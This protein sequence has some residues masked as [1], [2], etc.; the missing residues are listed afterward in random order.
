MPYDAITLDTNVFTENGYGLEHG[1]LAQLSQFK[2]GAP[3]FVLS[4]IVRRELCRHLL[5]AAAE[6]RRKLISTVK[7]ARNSGLLPPSDVDTLVEI[8]EAAAEPE[9]VVDERLATFA[10][11]TGMSIVEAEDIKLS[12]VLNRYFSAWPPF[13]LHGDKKKEFPDA[14]ALM[15]LDKWAVAN[16]LRLLAVSNDRGWSAYAETSQYID[17]QKDLATALSMF[18]E[19]HTQAQAFVTALIDAANKGRAKALLTELQDT[20]AELLSDIDVA[21]EFDS[22]EHVSHDTVGIKIDSLFLTGHDDNTSIS[23]VRTGANRIVF[24]VLVTVNIWAS[25]T[26]TFS[27]WADEQGT[28]NY[29]ESSEEVDDW[30]ETDLLIEIKTAGIFPAIVSVEMVHPPQEVNFGRVES[31]AYYEARRG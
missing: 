23:I 2:A 14:I 28:Y 3:R 13:E 19:Q 4:D 10:A 20:V 1:L 27:D 24:T 12:E 17:V 22:N 25:T 6:H 5:A 8:C 26:F 21:A 16:G 9:D 15:S 18:Q 31:T 29:D 11:A 7:R 30:F